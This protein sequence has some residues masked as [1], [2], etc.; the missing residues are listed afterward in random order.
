ML[1]ALARYPR[2]RCRLVHTGQHYDQ[3]MSGVFFD[4]LGIRAPDLDLRVGSDTHARQMARIMLAFDRTLAAEPPDL[5]VVVGDVNSTLACAMAAAKR[6]IRVA[7]VEAG[8]R[9]GDWSMPE[10]LN[11]VLTDRLSE[12]LFAPSVDAVQNLRR[13][14][15]PRARVYLVGNVMVDTLRAKQPLAERSTILTRLGLLTHDYAVLT[16]HRPVNVDGAR[17]LRT[18]LKLIERVGRRLRVVFPLHPRARREIRRARLHARLAAMPNVTTTR[19][20]GYLDFVKLMAHARVVLTDSGG[21]QEETTVLGVPC[22]TLRE[23]TERPV[24]VTQGTNVIVGTG[25]DRVVAEIDRILAGRRKRGRIPAYWDGGAA[26]R[27]ARILARDSF[28]RRR[29]EARLSPG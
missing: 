17:R 7:H 25:P 21:V 15:L 23:T 11:R 10:E 14:G 22:L 4:E 12:Y 20:L 6:G 1:R 29:G 28:A 2:I 13:E 3:G 16:L 24:T 19:P 18:V 27:I 8:L 26:D 5:V 9:S